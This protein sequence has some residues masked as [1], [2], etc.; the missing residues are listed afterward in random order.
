LPSTTSHPG[1]IPMLRV[2]TPSAGIGRSE[3]VLYSF[4]KPSVVL[5]LSCFGIATFA[6]VC[7]VVMFRHPMWHHS[8]MYFS[9]T[10]LGGG[11]AKSN[12]VTAAPARSIAS[13]AGIN[14][15]E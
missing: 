2:H 15:F 12:S 6:Q 4:Q 1:S 14:R 8:A 5:A 9:A 11:S 13:F 7:E 10:A 3:G